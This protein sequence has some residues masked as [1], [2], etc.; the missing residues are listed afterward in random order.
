MKSAPQPKD[1]QPQVDPDSRSRI[2]AQVLQNILDKIAAGA[3]PT[4][5]EMRILNTATSQRSAGRPS[6]S[7]RW[8]IEHAATEFGPDRRTLAKRLA[9]ESIE[10]GADGRYSTRDICTAIFT[11]NS[12][13]DAKDRQHA[14]LL[15]VQTEN[16]RRERIP[17][18]LALAVWDSV[19][20]SAA[21]TLKAAKGKLLTA[22]KI[23]EIMIPMRSAELPKSWK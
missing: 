19:L 15:K 23:N 6:K 22:E 17:I 3:V 18:V 11:S 14:E 10:P 13:R 2:D 16:A 7:I 1:D 9:D 20:Q 5:R 8:T 21:A 12:P 4:E